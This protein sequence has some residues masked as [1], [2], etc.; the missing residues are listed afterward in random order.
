MAGRAF[1]MFHR[2]FDLLQGIGLEAGGHAGRNFQHADQQF[3]FGQ[4][5]D[6]A[7]AVDSRDQLVGHFLVDMALRVDRVD[8]EVAQRIDEE[9]A[10][11]AIWFG[12]QVIGNKQRFS[13]V[14]VH[15]AIG[16]AGPAQVLQFIRRNHAIGRS[17]S[18]EIA[19]MHGHD[20]AVL[21]NW[22]C[23]GLSPI[24]VKA[25]LPFFSGH[26]A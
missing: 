10:P 18:G 16:P 15:P 26:R 19:E 5:I 9:I 23:A 13:L 3:Q 12:Q 21:H 24:R 2:P 1:A 25:P 17:G 8:H 4:R 11:V 22:S 14:R 6:P 7:I 20:E